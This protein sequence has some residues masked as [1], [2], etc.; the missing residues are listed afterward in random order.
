MIIKVN[1][2]AELLRNNVYT[3]NQKLR[4]LRYFA[5][6]VQAHSNMDCRNLFQ[7]IPV[8]NRGEKKGVVNREAVEKFL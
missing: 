3:E 5:K 6:T 4:L 7:V 2:R 1:I 8:D